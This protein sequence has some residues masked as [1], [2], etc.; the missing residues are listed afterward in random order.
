MKKNELNLSKNLFNYQ[1]TR[2]IQAF[3]GEEKTIKEIAEKLNEKP[4]RLYYHFKQLEELELI[5]C[6]REKKVNNLIQKYYKSNIPDLKED[7]FTW[8]GKEAAENKDF[9]VSQ[10]HAYAEGAIAKLHEDLQKNYQNPNSEATILST[11]LTKE[12]W[13]ELNQKIREIISK[14]ERKNQSNKKYHA[15]YVIMTYLE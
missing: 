3:Q 2:I 9:I 12:E 4:S 1:R 5:K 7:G 13:K 8:S 15:N 14:R 10:L 11:E 6:V